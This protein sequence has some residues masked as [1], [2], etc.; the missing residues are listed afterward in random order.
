MI[1]NFSIELLRDYLFN[2]KLFKLN[3]LFY[4]KIIGLY[5]NSAVY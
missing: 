2:I 3:Y 1:I 4:N 5:T